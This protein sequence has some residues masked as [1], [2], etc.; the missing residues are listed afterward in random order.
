MVYS[1]DFF[2]INKAFELIKINN[3]GQ[4]TQNDL[5]PLFVGLISYS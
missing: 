3:N 2:A 4:I 5:Q 1:C